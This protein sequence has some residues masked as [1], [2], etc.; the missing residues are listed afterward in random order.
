MVFETAMECLQRGT[1]CL[2]MKQIR[3]V[4]KGLK[5]ADLYLFVRYS[6]FVAMF[7]FKAYCG[8]EEWL[9]TILVVVLDGGV[10]S[11]LLPGLFTPGGGAP[12]R[13]E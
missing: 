8:L 5:D 13:T 2:Y 7:A 12:L 10:W 4:F 6:K 9:H 11:G 3:F 1:H